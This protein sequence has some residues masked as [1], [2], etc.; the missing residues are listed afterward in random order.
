MPEAKTRPTDV[1]ARDFIEAINHPVRRADGL[2]LLDMMQ[3]ASGHP[4]VMWGPSIVGFGTYH[5]RYPTGREGDAAPIGFSPRKSS[6]SLY[7]L[8]ADPASGDLLARLGKHRVG[9]ACLYVNTLADVDLGILR[10]LTEAGYRHV[11][12]EIHQP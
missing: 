8:T 9:A 1:N 2:L 12:S 11:M 5:Y 4:P 10:Q 6:L 3:E 7:G